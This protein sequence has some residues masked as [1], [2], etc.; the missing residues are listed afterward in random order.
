MPLLDRIPGIRQFARTVDQLWQRT[1]VIE[2][3][4]QGASAQLRDAG[5]ALT[6]VF[7]DAEAISVRWSAFVNDVRDFVRS[8]IASFR[9]TARHTVEYLNQLL[10]EFNEWLGFAAMWTELRE[11]ILRELRSFRAGPTLSDRLDE[12]E[13]SAGATLAVIAVA[14]LGGLALWGWWEWRT[15]SMALAYAQP[16]GFDD[17]LR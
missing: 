13:S 2:R 11:W 7:P 3:A 12:V 1:E 16:G 14:A 9:A 17:P 8:A 4:W 10:R 15:R 5:T 6:S